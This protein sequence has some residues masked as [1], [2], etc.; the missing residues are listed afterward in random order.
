MQGQYSSFFCFF[1]CVGIG[2]VTVYILS[3]IVT[4][5]EAKLTSP[6]PVYLEN[7]FPAADPRRT[8]SLKHL[9]SF[10]SA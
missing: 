4:F 5:L 1:D 9:R 2:S 6:L 10:C 8:D 7:K 3:K